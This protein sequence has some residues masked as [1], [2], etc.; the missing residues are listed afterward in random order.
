MANMKAHG[1]VFTRVLKG[2]WKGSKCFC[3]VRLQQLRV[4]KRKAIRR[5]ELDE[6]PK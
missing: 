5:R 1:G 6:D 4:G 2:V 3:I